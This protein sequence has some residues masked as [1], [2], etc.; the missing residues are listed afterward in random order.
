MANPMASN[1]DLPGP[2]RANLIFGNALDFARNPPVYLEHLARTYGDFVR[3]HILTQPIYL[4]NDPE[5]V[6]QVL[7]KQ[8][9]KFHK[10]AFV[11]RI[12][13]RFLGNGLSFS[14]GE[15][16]RRQ[17]RLDRKSTRLNS[18]HLGISYA[19]FCLK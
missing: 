10:Q 9:D 11:K 14:D 19:V 15:F 6:Y 8:A 2:K 12:L 4:V 18:S 1:H 3:F 7:V 5:L 17:R 16:W 13:K